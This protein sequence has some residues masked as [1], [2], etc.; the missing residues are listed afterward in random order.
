MAGAGFLYDI[1]L[2]WLRCVFCATWTGP[3][4]PD[5]MLESRGIEVP[6]MSVGAGSRR[7]VR[8][9]E[10]QLDLDTAELQTNRHTSTLTGQPL[11][12]LTALLERPGELVTREELKKKL[13]PDDTFVD[14][15]QSL[16]KAVNRLREALNDSAEHPRFI[17]TLPRRG[18]RFTGSVVP[19]RAEHDSPPSPAQSEPTTPEPAPVAFRFRR[20]LEVAAASLLLGAIA[21]VTSVGFERPAVPAVVATVRLTNDGAR[22]YSLVTDGVRLYFSGRGRLFQASVDGGETTE[23]ATGLKEVDLYDISQHGSQLLVSAGVQGSPAVERALWTISLPSGNPHRLGEIKA[24]WASWS[25][26]GQHVAYALNDGVYLAKKDGT[27]IRKLTG[28]PGIPEKLQFSPDGGRIRF[29][30]HDSRRNLASIW[31]ADTNGRG[32]RLLFPEIQQPLHTGAWSEDGKYFFFNSHEPEKDLDDQVWVSVES[33]GLGRSR[34][35]AMRLTSGPMVFGYAVPSP[36]GK[37]VYAIGTQSRAELVRYDSRS[38]QFLPYLSGISASLAEVSRDGRW[39]VYVSYPD[40][41]L[42][43]CKLDGTQRLQLTT[44]PMQVVT[45]QWSPDGTRIVFTDVEPGKMWKIYVVPAAG[46]KAE[47]LLPADALSEIDPSWS[48]DGQSIVFG[49]S[50]AEADRGIQRIDLTTHAISTLPGSEGLFSPR[51]S[52]DGRYVA[53]FPADASKLML[54]DFRTE[55]WAENGQGPFQFNIWSRDGKKIYLLA[56]AHDNEIVRFDIARR[57]FEHVVSLRHLEQGNREWI[58][59][60]EDDAPLVTLDK[61]VSDVYRLDLAYK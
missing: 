33:S 28:V 54:Y 4:T 31:E 30:V 59:L 61:S 47:E 32:L 60:A 42:W 18:Y 23:V 34:G 57:Q 50:V 24:L 8:F 56:E 41:A 22:K 52:P 9:G 46:G 7:R 48:P 37:H 6:K 44:P 12:I 16:N 27:E 38:N 15:D 58:G 35:S 11:Q 19:V 51:L 14:F 1:A 40:L 26:D 49:R 29:D 13:W 53:A 3:T 2:P 5:S 21:L 25:H 39:I 45:P 10:Y 20:P 36:D 17:E 43:R 55:Q